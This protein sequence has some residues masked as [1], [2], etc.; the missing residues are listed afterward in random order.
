MHKQNWDDLRFILAVAETGSVSQAAR[1]LGVNHATVLRRVADF[2]QRHGAAI[3]EKTTRGYRVIADKRDVIQAAR[4]AQDAISTV[5]QLA[6]GHLGELRGKTRVTSTDTFCQMLLPTIVSDLLRQSDDLSIDVI[7]SNAHVDLAKHRIDVAIRPGLE[8]GAGLEGDAVARLGFAVYAAENNNTRWLGLSGPLARSLGA[9]WMADHIPQSQ[10]IASADSFYVLREL[11]A[12]GCGQA[13]LPCFI[14]DSDPR[15][16]R[17]N[18]KMPRI[19]V[20]IW[21]ASH[22]DQSTSARIRM[23]RTLLTEALVQKADILHG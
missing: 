20:P 6:G 17:I 9:R 5:E 14:G 8:L 23:L 19:E 15:L 13:I 2:E 12:T 10:I 1:R 22:V 21:V 7:S 3:F 11:V 4:I 16:S 18:T